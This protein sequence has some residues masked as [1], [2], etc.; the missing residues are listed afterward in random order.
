MKTH[1]GNI[2]KINVDIGKITFETLE[3]FD[4]PYDEIYFGK[5]YAD[6]Y[7][8]DLE[9]EL[10]YYDNK[11]DPRDF[12]TIQKGN[13]DTIIKKGDLK[14][15][16]FYYENIP[17]CLKDLFPIYLSG[18]NEAITIEKIIGI[19]VTEIYLSEMLNKNTFIHILNS[20]CR[21]QDCD[22]TIDNDINLYNNYASKLINRYNNFDYSPFNNSEQV[23]ESI[24][25]K[26]QYYENNN[27]G[28][29]KVIHGDP[30]FTNI[31]INKYGKIKFIDMRGKIGDELTIY[32]DWLYDWAKIYQ[33]IIGYDEIL[34]SKIIDSNYKENIINHFKIYFIEKFS[35][36]DFEN[37]KIITKSL[38]FT[39]I[40][41]HNNKKC[42]KYYN[43]LFSSYLN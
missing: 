5:P 35:E 25:E 13:I 7:I 12:H 3:K 21:I 11:I 30:V 24:L 23:Y 9:K 20:I 39:L 37:L 28:K 40:P 33:S 32:G 18:D 1:S 43:L 17:T 29:K 6:F 27:F 8:D 31:M 19:T 36:E 22:I 41:L 26:L 2:G 4:I 14:G 38:I 10:G 15:E 42:I 34:L 16:R